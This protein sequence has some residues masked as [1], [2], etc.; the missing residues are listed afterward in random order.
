MSKCW[1]LRI[2]LLKDN[3]A[4]VCPDLEKN[5]PDLTI[6]SKNAIKEFSLEL[7]KLSGAVALQWLK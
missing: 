6:D 7:E 3:I 1:D 2:Y 5:S 4:R